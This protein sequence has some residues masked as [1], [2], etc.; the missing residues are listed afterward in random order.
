MRTSID[1]YFYYLDFIKNTFN[2]DYS[3]GSIEGINNF[4][5]T[6]KRIALGYRNFANFEQEY[7]SQEIY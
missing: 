5:K 4:I 3:N 7:L 6:L 2:Y 1:N